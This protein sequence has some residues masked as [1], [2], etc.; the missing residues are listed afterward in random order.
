MIQAQGVR[1]GW[2]AAAA[3]SAAARQGMGAAG[4]TVYVSV[5]AFRTACRIAR[6]MPPGAGAP[7]DGGTSS[8][9]A[10]VMYL[11]GKTKLLLVL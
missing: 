3:R 7:G 9:W 6:V 10:G 11:N 1:C 2:G 5:V 8:Y 4:G